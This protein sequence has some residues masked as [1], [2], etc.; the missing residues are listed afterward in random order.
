MQSLWPAIVSVEERA[1]LLGQGK[2]DAPGDGKR[3]VT[4]V[5]VMVH[6]LLVLLEDGARCGLSNLV[7]D[8]TARTHTLYRRSLL[9][10]G[11]VND[12]GQTS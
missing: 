8:T 9:A 5:G 2:G 6:V 11:M 4:D 7:T 12:G 3:V 1:W 10:A